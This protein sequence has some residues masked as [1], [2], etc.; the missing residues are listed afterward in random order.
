M[1]T[2]P[3]LS[4]TQY[5]LARHYLNKL[6]TADEAVR[7]GQA[8]IS[9]G[10]NLFD[11][12]WEQIR[13]WQAW[14]AKRKASDE[15]SAR[16]CK[17]F[18]LAGL[19][20]LASRNSATDQAD[21][22]M[23]ALAAAQQ[24]S[25]P[26]AECTLCYELFMTYYRLG[27][28]EKVEELAN[29]LL[30]LGEAANDALSIERAFF[31]FGLVTEDRGLYAEAEANYQRALELALELGNT[32]EIGQALNGLGTV[33]TYLGDYQKAYPYFV[34]QLE[35][36]ETTG[37]K[38]DVCHALLSMG[39]VLLWL[40]E[41][42]S[43]EDYLQRAVTMSR[44]LGLQRLL[45]VSLIH[46][47]AA[48]LEQN[49]LETAYR[50]LEEGLEAVRS[51]GVVRQVMS[52]LSLLGDTWMRLGNTSS[53]LTCLQE[54]LKMARES[55]SRR[56]IC[57]LQCSLTNT[58]LA[59]NDLDSAR[60]ALH[61][62]LTLAQSLSSRSEQVKAVLSAVAYYRCL[63]WNEQAARWAGSIQDEPDLDQFLF[64]SICAL[65]E[66]NLGAQRY[67]A[68]LETGKSLGLDDV[69]SQLISLLDPLENQQ[70]S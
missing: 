51:V 45:G 41:Y 38:S 58:Y 66:A 40:K 14:A 11:Q 43:A 50:Y 37:K 26:D 8:N 30:K 2:V 48:A 31:G 3:S 4:G 25:D 1:T 22:L 63:G 57:D 34:R 21:W 55:G 35:L 23:T 15:A 17:E 47:G 44:V 62:A 27:M 67:Q 52:G 16:L 59:L 61:E 10:L 64:L 12:D 54:G 7:R 65:V 9:Y 20:I 69:V 53:A 24:L 46:L 28:P 60:G 49:H 5:R 39:G 32:I 68:A 6:R 29:Q 70:L 13:H 33:A 19:E 18:P 36:M 56:Y 42:A